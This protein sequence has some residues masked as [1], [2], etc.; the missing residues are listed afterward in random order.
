MEILLKLDDCFCPNESCGDHGK[1]GLGNIIIYYKYGKNK[2]NLLKCKTCNFRFSERR[3]T[4]F[5]GLHTKESKI[6]EVILYLLEGMSFRE[7]ATASDIDKDTVSRIWKRF[8]LCCEESVDSL[9]KEFN[10]KIE[11]LI[12][13]LHKRIQKKAIR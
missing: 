6:K 5:F 2:R 1:K 8:V 4:F 7:A 9:L 11:D 10:L 3:S 13:L 12:M